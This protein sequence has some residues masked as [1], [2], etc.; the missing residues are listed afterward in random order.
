MKL[1]NIFI[2]GVGLLFYSTAKTL[3]TFQPSEGDDILTARAR[4]TLID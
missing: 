3:T 2:T 1:S 4:E